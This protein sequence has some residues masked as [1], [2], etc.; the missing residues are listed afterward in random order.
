MRPIGDIG[1]QVVDLVGLEPV[2]DRGSTRPVDVIAHGGSPPGATQNARTAH[3]RPEQQVCH[4][5]ESPVKTAAQGACGRTRRV[6]S[7]VHVAHGGSPPPRQGCEHT[8]WAIRVHCGYLTIVPGHQAHAG[9]RFG[10]GGIGLGKIE[11]NLHR[12]RR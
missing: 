2:T 8:R 4:I 11:R 12:L 1:D 5:R 9:Y 3:V 6:A 7:P 10:Y